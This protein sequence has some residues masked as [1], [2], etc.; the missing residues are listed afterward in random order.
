MT[1][2]EIEETL[3]YD[4]I[5][6]L[7]DDWGDPKRASYCEYPVPETVTIT[8]YSGDQ[9]QSIQ[10]MAFEVTAYANGELLAALRQGYSTEAMTAAHKVLAMRQ[11]LRQTLPVRNRPL[12]K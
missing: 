5:D 11:L 10:D 4:D 12:S 9:C 7:A 3:G 6:L 8:I 2:E 1:E